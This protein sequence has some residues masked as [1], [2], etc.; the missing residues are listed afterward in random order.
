MQGAREID[1]SWR[2]SQRKWE[3]P[4]KPPLMPS[5]CDGGRRLE[6]DHWL[7][8]SASKLRTCPPYS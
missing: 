4:N 7:A 1:D 3:D 8:R 5:N 6:S 2:F